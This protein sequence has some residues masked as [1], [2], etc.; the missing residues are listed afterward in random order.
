MDDLKL[1]A[2]SCKLEETCFNMWIGYN[3]RE[4]EL[5]DQHSSMLFAR[6]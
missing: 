2:R 1:K 5:L 6:L 3:L 4:I